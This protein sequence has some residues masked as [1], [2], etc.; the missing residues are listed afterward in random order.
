MSSV[1]NKN[2]GWRTGGRFSAM[3]YGGIAWTGVRIRLCTQ[4]DPRVDCHHSRNEGIVLGG[5][6]RPILHRIHHW[7]ILA[8]RKN[9]DGSRRR[10]GL[11]WQKIWARV[12]CKPRSFLLPSRCRRS[13]DPMNCSHASLGALVLMRCIR[14]ILKNGMVIILCNKNWISKKYIN[15]IKSLRKFG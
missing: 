5:L 1:N 11:I 8:R 10:D 12:I 7:E 4:I 3:K 13:R 9:S 2:I 14:F 15:L 6:S